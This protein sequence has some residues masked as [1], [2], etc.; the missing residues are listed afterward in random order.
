MD[1]IPTIAEFSGPRYQRIVEAMEADIASGRLVRGQQ[2]PTQRALAKTLGIDLTTVTRAYSEARRRGILDAR[3]G[4]GSFVSE[5][6][7]RRAIDLPHPVAIDL[8]MN[9]PPHPL[10]AQLDDRILAGLEAVRQQ[11]GLTAFLNYQPPGGSDRELQIAAR[12]MRTRVAHVRPDRLVIFP[13]TQA[14][15]FNLLAF[16][17]RPGDVVLTEALTFPGIKAAAARLGIRLAGVAMD[18]GGI[19]PDALAKACRELKPKAVYL[20]PTLHNPT[21]ATLS[22]ERRD[23]IARIIRDT[24]TTLI[25]DD[26][27]GLLDRSALPIANLIPERTY[28]ATTLSKCIAPALRVAYL[29]TPDAAA[30]QEMRGYLQ[31]AVQ[32]PA[33]LM[34]ALV[35]HWLESGIADRII[36]AIRNE[37][38]GRQQLAQRALKDF[39]FLAKP[40]AHHL[41]LRLPQGWS[42]PEVA[43]HLLR[44]GLAVIAS[45]AFAI[46]GTP[47]HAARLSL[48]AALNRAELTQAL[49]I[50][51][52]ALRKPDV[53]QIV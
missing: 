17:A 36:T 31:A 26:A 32:M 44:N 1:W 33:P 40:A 5:T 19:L 9:V 22:V 34:V 47:P 21:T 12:W 43:A 4:Q 18:E 7:A 13:G 42:R 14:I 38:I 52:D 3:V 8:S 51:V 11:S 41:W 35:T 30:Q 53:R 16:L 15:L 29:V 25:E 46:D 48:G 37:A 23:A 20:I 10:D 49:Q 2:L 45:D 39:Q 50:L 27:Y 6:S 24:G 28:L